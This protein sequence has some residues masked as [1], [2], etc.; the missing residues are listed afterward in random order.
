MCCDYS[1]YDIKKP[2]LQAVVIRYS[3]THESVDVPSD[4]PARRGNRNFLINSGI[5]SSRFYLIFSLALGQQSQ[6]F[7]VHLLV[8]ENQVNGAPV[9]Q[10]L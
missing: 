6:S 3:K 4:L 9:L 8:N 1:I 7:L 5:S 10:I 2:P